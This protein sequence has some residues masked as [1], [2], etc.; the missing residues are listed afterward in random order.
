MAHINLVFYKIYYYDASVVERDN[1]HVRFIHNSVE[2]SAV[3]LER[4]A[5]HA[6]V[7]GHPKR[8]AVDVLRIRYVETGTTCV[9]RGVSQVTFAPDVTRACKVVD[10]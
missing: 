5:H 9:V 3:A 6:I 10:M 2:V 7:R 8:Q 1:M 4:R